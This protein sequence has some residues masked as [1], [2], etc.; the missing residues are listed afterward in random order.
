MGPSDQGVD[1]SLLVRAAPARVIAAF[2]D[3][4]ALAAWW[5]VVRSVTTPR[6]LGAYA[7][8]WERSVVPDDLLGP[9][10]GV[11]HGTVV[12]FD[13]GRGFLVADAW[14]LPPE[15]EPLGPIALEV[16][17]VPDGAGARLRVRQSGFEPTPRWRRYYEIIDPGWRAS[18]GALRQLLERGDG[19]AR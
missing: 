10:G 9:L 16:A 14:W 11:L 2:F 6:V 4:A 17:C 8:E 13:A 19:G 7:V 12:D 5:Q 3:P 18:L 15:G 1:Q